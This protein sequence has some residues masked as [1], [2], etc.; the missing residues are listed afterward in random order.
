MA[1]AIQQLRKDV[2]A[3]REYIEEIDQRGYG[4]AKKRR[5]LGALARLS[6]T[7]LETLRENA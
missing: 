2:D 3:L 6:Q 5:L 1:V 7:L 4:Q